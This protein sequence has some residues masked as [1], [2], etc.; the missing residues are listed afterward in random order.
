MT[1]TH[2]GSPL[3]TPTQIRSARHALGHLWQLGRPLTCEE[4]ADCL[5]L[6]KRHTVAQMERDSGSRDRITGPV[7]VAISAMLAGYVPDGAPAQAFEA[8]R[9]RGS[10]WMPSAAIGDAA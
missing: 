10:T 2:H 5:G 1:A 4:M 8:M 6:A 9:A 7:S 3:L